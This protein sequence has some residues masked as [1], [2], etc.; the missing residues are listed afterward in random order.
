MFRWIAAVAAAA[1]IALSST[2]AWAGAWLKKPGESYVKLFASYL[3]TDEEYDK[4]GNLIPMRSGVPG[5]TNGTFEDITIGAYLEYGLSE[6]FTLV[7]TV[8]YK[9]LT[10]TWTE[11]GANFQ[12]QRDIEAT[13]GGMTDL[14]A[15][16]R[17]PLKTSGFPISLEGI[18]KFPLGYDPSPDLEQVP[19]LGSGKVD[20]GFSLLSGVSLW[21]FPGYI[22]GLG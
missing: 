9:L 16:V 3:F 2:S 1:I 14:R 11:L 7:A 4:D 22:N 10:S 21:P 8:P 20:A 18:V 19:P 12:V 15:G 17:Y 6:R 13:S 5:I